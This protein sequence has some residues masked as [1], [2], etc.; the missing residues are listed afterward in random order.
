LSDELESLG[1]AMGDDYGWR[2]RDKTGWIRREFIQGDVAAALEEYGLVETK[3]GNMSRTDIRRRRAAEPILEIEKADE[4]MLGGLFEKA[5]REEAIRGKI[6]EMA[7]DAAEH[8]AQEGP[9]MDR[10]AQI[11]MEEGFADNE[12]DAIDIVIELAEW[13][14]PEVSAMI[15]KGIDQ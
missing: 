9:H 10:L 4:E 13:W 3:E 8:I 15:R 1:L 12:S 6:M 11:V 14:M 7:W 2:K 5:L